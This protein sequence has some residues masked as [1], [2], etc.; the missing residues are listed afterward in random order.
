MHSELRTEEGR[1]VRWGCKVCVWTV[2]LWK[3]RSKASRM[4]ILLF[5]TKHFSHPLCFRAKQMLSDQS[6]QQ[7]VGLPS[8]TDHLNLI[9]NSRKMFLMSLWHSSIKMQRKLIFNRD[10]YC[11][12]KYSFSN[13]LDQ[14]LTHSFRICWPVGLLKL[15][16]RYTLW[17]IKPGILQDVR[18]MC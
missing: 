4:R 13:T 3:E 5:W 11:S 12:E 15:K 9:I 7:E 6:H 16:A 10:A 18:V 8:H 1:G 17:T 14:L 2:T